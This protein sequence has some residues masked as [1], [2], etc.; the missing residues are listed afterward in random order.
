MKPLLVLCLALL[1]AP[2]ISSQ[3]AVAGQLVSLPQPEHHAVSLNQGAV[4]TRGATAH[5][6]ATPCYVNTATTGTGVLG[7]LDVGE[8][9]IDWGL[10]GGTTGT[11]CGAPQSL[12]TSFEFGYATTALDTSFGGPGASVTLRFY[13]GYSGFG[14]D[15]GACPV[16]TFAFTGLPGADD[17]L[18]PTAHVIQVDLTGGSEFVLLDGAFGY[19]FEGDGDTVPTV[20]FTGDGSGGPDPCTGNVDAYDEWIGGPKGTLN[21]TFFFGGP[22]FDFASWYLTITRDAGTTSNVTLRNGAPNK[23]DSLACDGALVGATLELEACAPPGYLSAIFLAFDTPFDLVL[24]GGQRVLC[25]DLGGS[26]ELFTGSG[27]VGTPAGML[28]GSP[29]FSTALAV[30]ADPSLVGFELCVQAVFA[31]GVTP[32]AMSSACDITVGG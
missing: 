8:E 29:L 16:A 27:V 12:V 10:L 26:G 20:C 32:F 18:N 1:S 17:F 14:V 23:V 5:S 30:P 22:P 25:L 24:S 6:S 9:W 11:K 3:T 31:F 28:G 7:L 4:V 13:G 21:G 2:S 19:G 15:A